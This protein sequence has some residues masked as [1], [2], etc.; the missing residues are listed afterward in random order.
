MAFGVLAVSFMF[1][2]KAVENLVQSSA[3]LYVDA[4]QITM[5]VTTIGLFVP[6]L[7]W[8][9][10]H[11]SAG[12]RLVYF[13]E[14]GYGA[15][16]L[17]FAQKKSWV[18]TCAFLV[19]VESITHRLTDVPSEVLLQLVIAVM[20]GTMSVLFLYKTRSDGDLEFEG[21]DASHA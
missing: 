9:A 5:A 17:I 19:V 8:K 4:F 21:G 14:D 12:E 15:Q 11:R 13:S 2:A 1:L 10:R 7:I 3:G 6:I 20:L 16:A 18:L